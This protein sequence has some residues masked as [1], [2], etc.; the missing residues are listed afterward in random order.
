M[1]GNAGDVSV[2]YSD[3][4]FENLRRLPST[5]GLVILDEHIPEAVNAARAWVVEEVKKKT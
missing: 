4:D 1:Q 2:W 3:V 5:R